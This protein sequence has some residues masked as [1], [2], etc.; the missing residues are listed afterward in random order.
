MLEALLAIGGL[1]LVAGLG[2]AVASRVFYVYVD[3]KIVAVE[4]AL[5]GANCGGC[6]YPGCSGAAGAIVRGAAEPNVCVAGGSSVHTAIAG[7]LGVE[8]KER[9][10]EIARPGCTYGLDSADLKYEYDGFRGCGGAVL[11]DGGAK[12]CPVGCLGLGTCV[13]ACPFGALSMGPDN[14]PVVDEELCTGC[15]TCERVCPKHIITLSSSTRRALREY[16]TDQCSA[17][18]QRACPAGIN[19]PEYI[20]CIGEGDYREAVRIIKE[21]NPFP[22]VCG[23]ICV[24]PCEYECRRNLVDQGVAINPL[25]RF[26]SDRERLSG[27]RVPAYRAPETGRRIAVIGGGAEGLTASYFLN[28]MGHE[29]VVYEGSSRMGGLLRYGLPRNRL[30]SDV[31]DWDIEGVREAGVAFE[32]GQRL[33]RDMTVGSL[34]EEGYDAVLVALGGWDTQMS[35]RTPGEVLKPLPGVYLLLDFLLAFREGKQRVL[36]KRVVI[37][38]GGSAALEAARIHIREDAREVH[39]VFRVPRSRAPFSEEVLEDAEEQGIQLHFETAVTR[40]M[41]RDDELTHLELTRLDALHDAPRE[42]LAADTFLTGSGRFPELVYVP[43]AGGGDVEIESRRGTVSWETLVPY[44]G[45]CATEATGVFRPGEANADYRA[46]VEAM[47]S[48]RRA[49]ATIQRYLSG[50]SVEGPE[51]MI[52]A[53]TRVLSLAELEPVSMAPREPVPVPPEEELRADPFLEVESTYDE[54]QARREAKRCLQCGL[55]CY[56]R[57]E[58]PVH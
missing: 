45:P 40:M 23:R 11:L 37:L 22:S 33:G 3:P 30:P 20:R 52:R 56:R 44:A 39:M 19:V 54:D 10:P 26:A 4:E 41:G 35:Q 14:L 46:V 51:H 49:S 42:I 32:T 2:L 16:T 21:T 55:I 36:G 47:G 29:S 27:E 9:E 34:L 8:I 17:P 28:R 18:C 7:L 13:R 24:H 12:V 43:Q 25:K 31:L 5:P 48:G 53:N 50:E 57:T 1:G 6:G 58:G 15:G 38:G